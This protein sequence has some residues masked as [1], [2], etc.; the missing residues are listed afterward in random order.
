[1]TPNFRNMHSNG[2]ALSPYIRRLRKATNVSKFKRT[3][4]LL[5]FCVALLYPAVAI[6]EGCVQN[7]ECSGGTLV[8]THS[9]LK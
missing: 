9:L 4:R 8:G 7:G 2:T 1:M 6:P 3:L 5:I